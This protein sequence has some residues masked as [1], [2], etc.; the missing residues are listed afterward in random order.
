MP[1]S[2]DRPVLRRIRFIFLLLLPLSAFAQGPSAD[3]RTLATPHFRV[4]YPASSEAWARGA[5][6]RLESIRQRVVAEVGYDPP[7]VVDVIVSDPVADANGDGIGDDHRS[8]EHTSELQSPVHIVCR[9][10]L[11]KKK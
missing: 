6:A 11:E 7:E 2:A 9:L 4:H 1:V 10:L 3:W 8:E 5:G